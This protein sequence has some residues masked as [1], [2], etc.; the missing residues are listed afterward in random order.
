MVAGGGLP[1][2]IR[3]GAMGI[4]MGTFFVDV[5]LGNLA[6]DRFLTVNALVDTGSTITALP[7]S[8]LFS[9]GVVP[10]R[11]ARF[12]LADE[13]VVEYPV[14]NASI[15]YNGETVTNPVVFTPDD[16]SPIIGAVTL[17]ALALMVDP[18]RS[19]LVPVNFQMR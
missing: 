11:R 1:D 10:A 15:R 8:L 3:Q 2:E 9:L 17:E 13:S 12:E 4:D 16:V 14:G 6:G 7:E 5:E 19:R 18:V